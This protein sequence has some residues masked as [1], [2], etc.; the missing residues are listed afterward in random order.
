MDADRD[1][2]PDLELVDKPSKAISLYEKRYAAMLSALQ[3]MKNINN[4]A[5][6]LR[7]AGDCT[8]LLTRQHCRRLREV[9]HAPSLTERERERGRKNGADWA[10]IASVVRLF[11]QFSPLASSVSLLSQ[12]CERFPDEAFLHTLLGKF[13]FAAKKFEE[14]LTAWDTVLSLS[15]T[16]SPLYCD[17][18][19]G[20]GA[21][22]VE[23]ERVDESCEMYN[24]FL[25]HKHS[26]GHRK[27]PA[28]YVRIGIMH[29]KRPFLK[30]GFAKNCKLRKSLRENL[31]PLYQDQ[32]RKRLHVEVPPDVEEREKGQKAEIKREKKREGE[33]NPEENNERVAVYGGS[34]LLDKECGH[35]RENK[36]EDEERRSAL[37]EHSLSIADSLSFPSDS[38]SSSPSVI[39]TIDKLLRLRRKS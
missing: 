7:E 18:L 1:L 17:G 14:S 24:R 39:N 8:A 10:V 2:S 31:S 26:N 13:L 37:F 20:K 38:F 36:F 5:N 27:V 22:L 16:D 25:E 6:I 28:A 21:S 19:F 11:D 33:Q 32:A 23:L 34:L 15:P 30:E 12:Y 3:Q 4:A 29:S 9:V 35:V